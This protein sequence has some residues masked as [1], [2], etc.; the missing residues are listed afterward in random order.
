M[1]ITKNN[2]FT[3]IESVGL[4]NLPVEIREAHQ[5]ITQLTLQG[6]D[7]S[8]LKSNES[9]KDIAELAFKKLG[10]FLKYNN[11][12]SGIANEKR[13]DSSSGYNAYHE[14]KLMEEFLS[15]D[16]KILI[17]KEIKSFISD[18][19]K[20]ISEK[21]IRKISPYAKQ[22]NRVQK[23]IISLYNQTGNAYKVGISEDFRQDLEKAIMTYFNQGEDASHTNDKINP[24]ELSGIKQ[25]SESKGEIMSS[26]E[27]T[28]KEFSCLGF[29]GKWYNLIGNPSAGFTAMVFGKP[30]MGKSYLCVDFAGYLSRN[31]GKVLYVA[32]EEKLD[33]TLQEKLKQKDVAHENLF[34]SDH[35]PEDLSEYDFI[36]LDSVNLLGLSPEELRKLKENN[37]GK[38]FVFVFQT[39]KTG[40]F[41][42]ANS[43]QHDVD[44]VIEIPERGKAVQ[45]G[46]FNQGGEMPIF[47]DENPTEAELGGISGKKKKRYSLKDDI[48]DRLVN[49]SEFTNL[50]TKS[51]KKSSD[52][53]KV[54]SF[55]VTSTEILD[56]L[57][58]VKE[59]DYGEIENPSDDLPKALHGK[60]FIL[61]R[62]NK[63]YFVDTQGYGYPRYMLRLIN[64]EPNDLKAVEKNT[65]K[66]SSEKT[67]EIEAELGMPLEEL[68]MEFFE[69]E[70]DFPQIVDLLDNDPKKV[71]QVVL[72]FA[73]NEVRKK[74]IKVLELK[75][76][77]MDSGNIWHGAA[78]FKVKLQGTKKQLKR[79]A[80]DDKLFFYDWEQGL[81]G[82]KKRKTVYPSWTRPKH[83]QSRDH[84]DLQKVFDLYTEGE[85]SEA[86]N[87]ASF[88]DTIV[89]DEIP[90]DIWKKMGGK[91][92]KTGEEKL[93]AKKAGTASIQ[94][95]EKPRLVFHG[96]VRILKSVIER[97]W[98][99]ELTDA[100]YIEILE[101]AEDNADDFVE[102]INRI[103]TDMGTF[104]QT[105][106]TAYEVWTENNSLTE[107]N[108]SKFDEEY[109][110]DRKDEENP[111]YLFS[112]TSDKVLVEALK[113]D[114]DLIY[115]VRRELANRGL[116]RNGKW[117]GF[118]KAAELHHIK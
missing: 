29:T 56:Q 3:T 84:Q 67:I 26:V 52:W 34:V 40:N 92:T 15:F 85:L 94:K 75:F 106:R 14:I 76:E 2:Y 91:L 118:K 32:K 4:E 8:R 62:E 28:K 33:R 63:K 83:L 81:T 112:I 116:D 37:P 11:G 114:F 24:M 78:Y 73:Q 97:E 38:S 82:T 25:E 30:K 16:G 7:W 79:V 47:E 100:E 90:G 58:I 23:A 95:V 31:F 53:E 39:T 41:R 108:K 49:S 99:V 89:R 101:I 107:R 59:E 98:D 42:G 87:F 1:K 50:L 64:Y 22:I 88:L 96:G 17:K 6:K 55:K 18:L 74:D 72:K 51:S 13:T 5:Y 115:M 61:I 104:L 20:A 105:I 86:Y 10:E 46:R 21:K 48:H 36:I 54:K 77:Q 111:T 80:G 45:F 110:K 70:N 93:K 69:E 60:V 103:H 117:V 9:F 113:G 68:A 12:L 35:L 44:V 27:F 57:P 66:S 43:F 102:T 19:Q 71:E 65:G 109:Y